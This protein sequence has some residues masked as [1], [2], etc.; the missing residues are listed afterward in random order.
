MG[1]SLSWAAVKSGGKEAIFSILNLRPTGQ[2][3]EIPESAVVG[4]LLPTGWY[5][6]L[7]NRKTIED[8]T[9]KRLS[10][11]GDVVYCFVEDHVMFSTASGWA[12]GSLRWSVTHDSE[13][14]GM[15]HL[16][17]SGQLPPNFANIRDR[18]TGEQD[19]HGGEMSDTD[20]IHDVPAELAKELTG[21]RH[22]QDVPGMTGDGFEVLERAKQGPSSFLGGL[23]RR[24][25]S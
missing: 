8:G 18:L 14:G 15:L 10:S 22:D 23:F 3:E 21:F 11:L 16:E 13:N 7:F 5:L 20:F 24:N 19:A 9:L 12:N 6:V 2:R 1:Y 25:N 4:V 17:A